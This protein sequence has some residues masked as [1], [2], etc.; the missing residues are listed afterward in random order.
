MKKLALILALL[1]IPCTAF[2]LEMLNDSS[3]DG[4]TG[5]AGVD[6]AVDDIQLFIN[7]DKMAWID[8]DGYSSL[9][10]YGCN[11]RGGA[12]AMSNFQI[13]VLNINA[14]VGSGTDATNE[15]WFALGGNLNNQ[16][17]NGTGMALR[18]VSCGKIPLFYDYGTGSTAEC[19][20]NTI[21]VSGS[22]LDNY[23]GNYANSGGQ[24]WFTPQFLSIDATDELPAASEGLETWWA[25]GWSQ[26]AVSQRN[27]D[28]NSTVGGVLIGLPTVEIYINDMY[29]KPV[30]DGDISGFTSLAIND[31]SKVGRSGETSDFGVIQL[32][33]VT[34]TVLS[35]WVEIAPH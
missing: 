6:I 17:L 7:I 8:C 31:D 29:F 24:N 16:S 19:F 21:G 22:G 34:F 12:I 15:G 3:L 2:G 1:I 18:S 5:Q 4:I 14:I 32:Q 35:G 25:N 13:D 11:G 23:Y 26:R 30:Y 27:G 20:L 28:G 33:G 9:G 10:R